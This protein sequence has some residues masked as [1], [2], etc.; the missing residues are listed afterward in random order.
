MRQLTQKC[1]R[2]TCIQTWTR[3]NI[4]APSSHSV[5]EV[6]EATQKVNFKKLGF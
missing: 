2:Y 5:R 1:G 4:T 3:M 6:Y